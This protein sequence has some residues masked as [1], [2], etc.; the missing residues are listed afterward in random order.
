MNNNSNGDKKSSLAIGIVA[1]IVIVTIIAVLFSISANQDGGSPAKPVKAT[2]AATE[3][4][5]QD[6]TSDDTSSDTSSSTV[7]TNTEE[8]A[9]EEPTEAEGIVECPNCATMVD[10]LEKYNHDDGYK[11]LMCADCLAGVEDGTITIEDVDFESDVV[12]DG[13]QQTFSKPTDKNSIKNNGLC[14]DCYQSYR[15]T[16][17]ENG[18]EIY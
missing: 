13:C 3:V 10:K 16:M 1:F 7:D 5:A 9:E 8:P 4:V 17:E 14:D 18:V 11:K 2:E 6:N 15:T 12:C